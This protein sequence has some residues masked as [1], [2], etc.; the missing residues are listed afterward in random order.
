MPE[1][2]RK[3]WHCGWMSRDAWKPGKADLP[4][5]IGGEDYDLDVCP[6]WVVR[7]PS[8]AETMQAYA[9]FDGGALEAFFPDAPN[10]LLEGVLRA[11]QAFNKFDSDRLKRSKTYL[12]L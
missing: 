6:G 1:D 4:E 9:A 11:R 2:V 10:H 3:S 7:Q 5:T 8:I 12:C